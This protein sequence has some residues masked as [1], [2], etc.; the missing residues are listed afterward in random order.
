VTALESL[1]QFPRE[2]LTCQQI[3]TVLNANPYA[4]HC[5]AMQDPSKLGFP[6]IVAG[7]R[8]KV[9]KAPFLKFMRGE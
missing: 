9:P 6:V 2:W 1:E 5:Q 4:L 8:V 3:A 7:R